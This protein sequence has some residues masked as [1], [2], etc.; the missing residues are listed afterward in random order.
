LQGLQR[1]GPLGG[2]QIA[3][4]ALR[5]GIGVGLILLGGGV[6]GALAGS[7]LAGLGAFGLGCW[8]LRDVYRAADTTAAGRYSP[9][10]LFR[11]SL[12]VVLSTLGLLLLMN[13]DLLAVKSRFPPL[14]AGL[15]SAVVTLGR[16][17][18]FIPG[19]VVAL[20]FPKV[21]GRY[22]SGQP[23]AGL[24][25]RSL[26]AVIG[27]CGCAALILLAGPRLIVQWLYGPQFLGQAALLGRYGV[28]MLLLALVNVWAQYFMAIQEARYAWLLVG[29]SVL[30]AVALF[31][32]PLSL[33]GVIWCLTG[34]NGLLVLAGAWLLRNQRR[35]RVS[36]G[37]D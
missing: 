5:L 9:N 18:L 34:C 27:L 13:G 4:A 6:S 32:A 21:A 17:V 26:L 1:F 37:V 19:A 30:Q 20:M 35:R 16:I 15:Y 7:V 23:T 36:V 29:M 24:A 28:A 2:G 31:C 33:T 11:F 10:A 22:A 8:W 14:E 12:N 3:T 25:W